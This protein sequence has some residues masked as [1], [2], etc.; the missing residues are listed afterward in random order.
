MH[1]NILIAVLVISLESHSGVCGVVF[2]HL[3]LHNTRSPFS[4]E[5]TAL[6]QITKYKVREGRV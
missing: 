3:E 6:A 1:Q 2:A 5:G 4:I